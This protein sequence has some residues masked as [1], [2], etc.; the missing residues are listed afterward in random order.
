MR[1]ATA[2]MDIFLRFGS[3]AQIRATPEY[4]N[5]NKKF[6]DF[7]TRLAA[8]A[9]DE[10][11]AA[12]KTKALWLSRTR[13]KNGDGHAL[14]VAGYVPRGA[15]PNRSRADVTL[16][17]GAKGHFIGKTTAVASA[18][19]PPFADDGVIAAGTTP[20]QQIRAG[21]TLHQKKK[22]DKK[23]VETQV[24]E[25]KKMVEFLMSNHSAARSAA[26][27]PSE[28]DLDDEGNNDHNNCDEDNANT[29]NNNNNEHSGS[30]SQ[31]GDLSG[32]L[33]LAQR[34]KKQVASATRRQRPASS[35][36][37]E[38]HKRRVAFTATTVAT[39]TGATF[40]IELPA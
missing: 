32:N 36:K 6:V 23:K 28:D 38:K 27:A 1:P 29:Q 11:D 34:P 17:R 9:N 40:R 7:S 39:A 4:L 24:A 12:K 15:V 14:A 3:A 13:E 2:V 10:S 31:S 19:A 20:S 16:Q 26:A 37:D 22:T 8:F 25:L 21:A 33:V 5:A 18:T 30:P 35:S